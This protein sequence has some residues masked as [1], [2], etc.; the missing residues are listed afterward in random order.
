MGLCL[1]FLGDVLTKSRFIE[2]Q[3][4]GNRSMSI[5]VW[6]FYVWNVCDSCAEVGVCRASFWPCAD[7]SVCAGQSCVD[8][9]GEWFTLG[10][11]RTDNRETAAAESIAMA[12]V[13]MIAKGKTPSWV[14]VLDFFEMS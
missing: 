3:L 12:I 5:R 14:F 8:I 2:R 4:L 6:T 1:L 9:P 7:P 11:G 10:G 13:P